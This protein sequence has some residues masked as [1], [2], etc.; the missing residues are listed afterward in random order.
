MR[1]N[2]LLVVCMINNTNSMP[3]SI[4]NK[5]FQPVVQQSDFSSLVSST[6]VQTNAY[7]NNQLDERHE[8]V[9]D[10][11][12]EYVAYQRRK[13]LL[14]CCCATVTLLIIGIPF[15]M[16]YLYTDIFGKSAD[17]VN[18]S[19]D[20]VNQSES[21]SDVE[22]PDIAYGFHIM[23]DN[24]TN[25]AGI[26]RMFMPLAGVLN[27][28][29]PILLNNVTGLPAARSVF[30]FYETLQGIMECVSNTTCYYPSNTDNVQTC[31]VQ[32]NKCNGMTIS[33]TKD[34][35]SRLTG[36]WRAASSWIN[37][38][39]IGGG[40]YTYI[41]DLYCAKANEMATP[42]EASLMQLYVESNNPVEG[43]YVVNAGQ[44]HTII[45]YNTA[46]FE[47]VP[48]SSKIP[49]IA[50]PFVFYQNNTNLT[51]QSLSFKAARIDEYNAVPLADFVCSLMK[52]YT[53]AA[54]YNRFSTYSYV[55]YMC[56]AH[57]LFTHTKS[58]TLPY[59]VDDAN[60]NVSRTLQGDAD[61]M[62]GSN[63]V[64]ADN[65]D[66]LSRTVSRSRTSTDKKD[67]LSRSRTSTDKKDILSR[68][69][70]R[71]RT[72][73]PSISRTADPFNFT[74]NY[75]APES[76]YDVSVYEYEEQYR[77]QN[78]NA[79]YKLTNNIGT[80]YV[81]HDEN[82][83]PVTKDG[84]KIYTD[85]MIDEEEMFV[86]TASEGV[87]IDQNG[88]EV[89]MED[90]YN[91]H[92]QFTRWQLINQVYRAPDGLY[93]IDSIYL[94]DVENKYR[95]AERTA[96]YKLALDSDP[97]N[98]IYAYNNP[99][100]YPW[101][102]PY[103]NN[104]IFAGSEIRRVASVIFMSGVTVHDAIDWSLRQYSLGSVSNIEADSFIHTQ[105]AFAFLTS[106]ITGPNPWSAKSTMTGN[107]VYSVNLDDNEWTVCKQ[108]SY[109]I[110][111]H[112]DIYRKI[113]YLS[114]T[115]FY[116]KLVCADNYNPTRYFSTDGANLMSYN[117]PDA[118]AFYLRPGFF[119]L[120]NNAVVIRNLGE[121]DVLIFT[122]GN[123]N[124]R[125]HRN[126]IVHAAGYA[127]YY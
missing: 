63:T 108:S 10:H 87:Y 89:Y 113:K 24:N 42:E 13:M 122:D 96:V 107:T 57:M 39:C 32:N 34:G 6:P 62:I 37:A 44:Y 97:S 40:T 69:V 41:N 92:S 20:I 65:K 114:I 99:V 68:T 104:T 35:I 22:N 120:L 75:T 81:Y 51:S 121:G 49:G 4:Q 90:M 11:Q 106:N 50:K 3:V 19:A 123:G 56:K 126:K 18:Q 88:L 100:R 28:T 25:I 101:S 72:S 95:D 105:T 58:Q 9:A 47:T 78:H 124:Y 46:G 55:I 27:K 84:L 38:V 5:T 66:I 43:R 26:F 31:L 16:L 54:I 17:I 15:L 117:L 118:N 91:T 14:I 70:S 33:S 76:L 12:K 53:N 64:T 67:I 74:L 119:D 102:G 110:D 93:S 85:K 8:M 52:F 125:D 98:I 36:K 23:P 112:Q 21:G 109:A 82:G 61:V 1:Y 111:I 79:V 115:P 83:N 77:D 2:Y 80:I 60:L 30:S 73:T 59:D 116:K 71:S 86:F 29:V 94:N 103:G 48:S 7:S 45:G 127:Y